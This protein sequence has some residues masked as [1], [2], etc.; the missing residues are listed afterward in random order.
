MPP[1]TEA[2]D[3]KD[4]GLRKTPGSGTAAEDTSVK[5]KA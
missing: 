1:I 4:T 2:G 3:F 5:E